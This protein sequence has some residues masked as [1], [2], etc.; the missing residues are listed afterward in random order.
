MRKCDIIGAVLFWLGLLTCLGGITVLEYFNLGRSTVWVEEFDRVTAV[1][2]IGL[3][4]MA[5]SIVMD[6]VEV[7]RCR[8]R[9]TDKK[10]DRANS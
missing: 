8:N 6:L 2:V 7:F 4:M 3:V 9:R 1:V 10:E 5:A